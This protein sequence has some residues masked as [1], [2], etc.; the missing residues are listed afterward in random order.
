M[1]PAGFESVWQKVGTLEGQTFRSSKG[2]EFT[3]RFTRTYLVVSAGNQSI[4]RTFFEKI[5]RRLEDGTVETQPSLQGQ[6][7]MLGILTDPRVQEAR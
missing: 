4:P 7:F 6:T 3:Y 1:S 5:H 2:V